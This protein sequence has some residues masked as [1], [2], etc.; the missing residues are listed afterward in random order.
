MP[1]PFSK[2]PSLR[3]LVAFEAAARSGKFGA[4]AAELNMTQ[5]AVSQHVAQLEA[6]IGTAL[7]DRRHR[8]VTLT[9][10]GTQLLQS[11]KLGLTELVEGAA[12]VRRRHETR[13]VHIR[14]DFGFASWWLMPRMD[15][16]SAEVPGVEVRMTTAQADI[17]PSDSDFDLAVLFGDG[18]WPRFRST[19][20][21][22]EEVFPVCTP[23]Y[24]DGRP[25]PRTPQ[26]IVDM[27]LLHLHSDG[28]QRWFDWADWFVAHD[29]VAPR[30]TEGPTFSN[31]QLV[32]QAVL[33]GQG[34]ALGFTPL[35]DD[36]VASGHLVRL[37]QAPLR[38][39]RGY[40]L[41]EPLESRGGRTHETVRDWLRQSP[42]QAA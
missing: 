28:A 3:S 35:I 41:V 26:D 4:A 37:T 25:L 7:F 6:D 38:S 13:S 39:E 2:M 20:L 33:M 14:T 17:T 8:G 34:V 31:F 15:R 29:L 27:R 22:D 18:H 36:L 30:Q 12:A 42:A 5:A 9:R 23:A 24:L 40:Y 21:W 1:G 11:V 32:L 19:R 10:A 16:L